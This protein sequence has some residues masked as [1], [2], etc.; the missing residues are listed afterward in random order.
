M[1]QTMQ[2]NALTLGLWHQCGC[3]FALEDPPTPPSSLLFGLSQWRAPAGTQERVGDGEVH[4]PL[5]VPSAPSLQ[6]YLSWLCPS[7]Q[8]RGSSKR[9]ILYHSF[10]EFPVD[11]RE[12]WH[13]CH[14]TLEKIPPNWWVIQC[15]SPQEEPGWHTSSWGVNLH[16]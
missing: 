13:V 14:K 15:E 7:T 16:S 10:S 1:H 2:E 3:L 6:D 8:G 12:Q 5:N 4:G 11:P 9:P